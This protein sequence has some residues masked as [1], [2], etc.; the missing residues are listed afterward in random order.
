MMPVSALVIALIALVMVVFHSPSQVITQEPVVHEPPVGG[1]GSDF[2]FPVSINAGMVNAGLI[3]TTSQGDVTVKAGEFRAWTDASLVSFSPGL[4][5]GTAITLPA[6]STLAGFMRAGD[7]KTFC[8]QNATSTSGVNMTFVSGLGTN[9][10]VASSSATAV[11]SSKLQPAHIGCFTIFRGVAT[12][13]ANDFY[14]T[15]TE[16]Q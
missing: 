1:A 14:A 5:A 6:S 11:G 4:L 12:S 13:T 7:R 15:L 10:S 2:F 3:A 16:F 8:I 9:L